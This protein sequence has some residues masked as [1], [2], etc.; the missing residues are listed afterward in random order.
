MFAAFAALTTETIV[1]SNWR[2]LRR[3]LCTLLLGITAL[4]T[5]PRNANAQLLY[6]CQAGNGPITSNGSVGEYNAAT[7]AAINANFITGLNYPWALALSGNTL[8]V[9]K[10]AIGTVGAYNATTGAPIDPNFITLGPSNNPSGLALSG[11]TL[12]VATIGPGTVGAYNA[13]TGAPINPSFIPGLNHPT[14]LVVAGTVG[15]PPPTPTPTPLVWENTTTGQC[16]IWLLKNGV[17]SGSFYLPTVPVTWRIAGVGDFNGDGNS[18]L[19]W[20]DTSTA[21]NRARASVSLRDT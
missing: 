9:S 15:S 18:D 17:F 8:F 14:G 19:V 12:F 10:Y 11:N 3:A 6:V 5:M 4:W 16:A 21:V 13:T 1:T 7:G 2:P 20:E